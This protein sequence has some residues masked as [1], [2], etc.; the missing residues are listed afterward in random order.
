MLKDIANETEQKLD[1]IMH[2]SLSVESIN[3]KCNGCGA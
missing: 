1:D 3:F 2:S